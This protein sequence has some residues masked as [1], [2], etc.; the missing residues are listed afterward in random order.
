MLLFSIYITDLFYK[1][2]NSYIKI[3]F[4]L[5]H[6]ACIKDKHKSVVQINRR[7]IFKIVF[8]FFLKIIR[9]VNPCS[10]LSWIYNLYLQRRNQRDFIFVKLRLVTYL[11]YDVLILMQYTCNLENFRFELAVIEYLGV[12]QQILWSCS[13][14]AHY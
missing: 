9:H 7:G 12:I 13:G 11:L 3:W 2:I 5:E 14:G 1:S 10:S 4:F 8:I 6:S